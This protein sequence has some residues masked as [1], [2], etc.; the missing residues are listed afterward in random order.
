MKTGYEKAGMSA[1]EEE[2]YDLGILLC[3]K[4]DRIIDLLERQGSLRAG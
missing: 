2:F 3:Q 1:Q 4:L